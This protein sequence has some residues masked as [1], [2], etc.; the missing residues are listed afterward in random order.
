MPTAAK[1]ETINSTSPYKSWDEWIHEAHQSVANAKFTPL[2]S[3]EEAQQWKKEGIKARVG[4][5][6]IVRY[7][8][9]PEQPPVQALVPTERTVSEKISLVDSRKQLSQMHQAYQ[10]RPPFGYTCRGSVLA[11]IQAERREKKH[12]LQQDEILFTNSEKEVH[13]RRVDTP[14]A[15]EVSKLCGDDEI[16]SSSPLNDTVVRKLL[17]NEPARE[18][19]R[20]DPAIKSSRK[21]REEL[22]DY[23]HWAKHALESRHPKKKHNPRQ[24]WLFKP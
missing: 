17:A 10:K 6:N 7:D 19:A 3:F 22:F 16:L 24:P 18:A 21:T 9:R 8:I 20:L 14:T 2:S 23:W 11:E 15:L 1:L 5:D 12:K 13:L 4:P